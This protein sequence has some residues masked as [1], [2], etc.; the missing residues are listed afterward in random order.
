MISLHS[1]SPFHSCH[2]SYTL[3]GFSWKHFLITFSLILA[4]RSASRPKLIQEETKALTQKE[5]QG[6]TK[7]RTQEMAVP[8]GSEAM[9]DGE[10]VLRPWAEPEAG[11]QHHGQL[12]EST[13]MLLST[14]DSTR[15]GGRGSP[16]GATWVFPSMLHPAC[17]PPLKARSSS[18]Q[19]RGAQD[20]GPPLGS[21]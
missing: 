16:L 10:E 21:C 13:W 8:G 15:G 12:Q 18:G 6:N 14:M 20:L 19:Y 4:S 3:S 5:V 2:T 9:P 7:D 17:F 11:S 1:W